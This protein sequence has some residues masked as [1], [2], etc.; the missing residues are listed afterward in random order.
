VIL[1][2]LLTVVD[3]I[4]PPGLLNAA[5]GLS[6]SVEGWY[7]SVDHVIH[8]LVALPLF[9]ISVLGNS[10]GLPWWQPPVTDPLVWFRSDPDGSAGGPVQHALVLLTY[11]WPV[12]LAALVSQVRAT[13]QR[14]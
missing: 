7:V 12:C 4:A 9:V 8:N 5:T 10:T 11:G 2:R 13:A 3:A 6:P 14:H 1:A